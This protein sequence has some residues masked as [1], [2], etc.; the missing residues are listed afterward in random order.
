[1]KK[2]LYTSI[3]LMGGLALTSCSK[4]F[5]ETKFYQSKNAEPLTSVEELTSFVNGAYAGMRNIGK[6]HLIRSKK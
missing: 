5:T 1:M 6:K 4:D 3:F 2:I